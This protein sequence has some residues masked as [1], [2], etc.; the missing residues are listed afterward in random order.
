MDKLPAAWKEGLPGDMGISIP[1][2]YP[3]AFTYNPK[4]EQLDSPLRLPGV[5]LGARVR[6]PLRPDVW[7]RQHSIRGIAVWANYSRQRIEPGR[8]RRPQG[9]ALLSSPLWP[10][11]WPRISASMARFGAKVRKRLE[12]FYPLANPDENV[13]AY[14]WARTVYALPLAR[15]FP[16]RRCGGC[17]KVRSSRSTVDCRRQCGAV[18]LSNR[19]RKIRASQ[20]PLLNKEL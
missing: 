16:C 9:H 15:S 14:L 20:R 18:P 12:P 1:Y 8:Q 3:R 6:S 19:D 5:G 10:N 13:S 7:W 4:V 11:A 2:G 17:K